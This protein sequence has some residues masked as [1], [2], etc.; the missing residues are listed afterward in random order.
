MGVLYYQLGRTTM[1][2]L[3]NGKTRIV[4][5]AGPFAFKIARIRLLHYLIRSVWYCRRAATII[6]RGHIAE[7]RARWHREGT[8]ACTVVKTAFVL[9][10]RRALI[11]G[12]VANF[13]ECRLTGKSNEYDLVPTICTLFYL[14]NV[15]VRGKPDSVL[16]IASHPVMRILA[17]TGQPALDLEPQQ[18]CT[19]RRRTLLA[20]YG[21]P[22]LREALT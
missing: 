1:Q 21:N 22:R 2:I 10:L 17:A 11:S 4:I 20:D 6:G 16:D 8:N 5:L 12:V 15:Q 18:F 13:T 7:Q 9:E 19:F 14:I 3:L